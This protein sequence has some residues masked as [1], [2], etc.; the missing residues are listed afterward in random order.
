MEGNN[1]LKSRMSLGWSGTANDLYLELGLAGAFMEQKFDFLLYSTCPRNSV[2]HSAL[3]HGQLLTNSAGKEAHGI[4]L[5]CFL[6]G[7]YC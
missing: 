7:G 5:F 2:N 6:G 1:S 4:A 3:W